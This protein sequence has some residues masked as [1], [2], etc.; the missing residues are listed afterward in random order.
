MKIHAGYTVLYD[1]YPQENVYLKI[2]ITDTAGHE[3]ISQYPVKMGEFYTLD[4][5]EDLSNFTEEITVDYRLVH[6]DGSLFDVNGPSPFAVFTLAV[7]GA[8]IIK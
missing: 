4:I 6:S 8:N 2:K 5:Q 1:W 3:A 7:T